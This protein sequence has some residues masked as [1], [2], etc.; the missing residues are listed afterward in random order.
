[1]Q[2]LK[3]IQNKTVTILPVDAFMEKN[4]EQRAG[5]VIWSG[6]NNVNLHSTL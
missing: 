6:V 2:R 4:A 3:F 5:L 1:M